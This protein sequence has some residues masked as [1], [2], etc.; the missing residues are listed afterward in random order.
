M[1]ISFIVICLE[2]ISALVTSRAN[3][4]QICHNGV[5]AQ[6]VNSLKLGLAY[7]LDCL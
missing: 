6:F 3:R 1:V 4:S 2:G 7:K 5:F